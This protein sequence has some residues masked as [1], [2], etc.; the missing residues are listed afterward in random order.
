MKSLLNKIFKEPVKTVE[1]VTKID[2]SDTIEE[3]HNAFNNEGDKLLKEAQELLKT[4]TVDNEA[5]SKQLA[6][7]GF[8]ATKEV[9]NLRETDRKREEQKRI[10]D[11]ITE[12]KRLYPNY[13]FITE[14]SAERIAKKYNLV[15]G[16]VTQYKG[17]V[18]QKN[19]DEI[20]LFFNNHPSDKQEYVVQSY[21]YSRDDSRLVTPKARHITK[22]EY[23]RDVQSR[24]LFKRDNP[25]FNYSFSNF[26][27][28]RNTI[29]SICAPISDMNTEGYKLNGWKLEKEIPDPIVM[30]AKTFNG[31]SGFII[32]TAWGD[33]ASDPE[34][35]NHQNN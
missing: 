10:A 29:L 6:E 4:L 23:E 1:S 20:S 24:E 18:P 22:E 11:A 30:K 27:L 17:F 35:V 21:T 26:P 25:Q 8:T 33:E 14:E 28:Q 32:I 9:N 19:L 15:L 13:R 2:Y 31:V 34:V 7:L 3:I 16:E 12:A 5:K